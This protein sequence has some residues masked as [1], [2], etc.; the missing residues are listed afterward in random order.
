MKKKPTFFK[1]AIFWPIFYEKKKKKKFK[2]GLM[3]PFPMGFFSFVKKVF[4]KKFGV[5]PQKAW[6]KRKKKKFFFG[7]F[8]LGV[9]A[10]FFKT[11]FPPLLKWGPFTFLKPK[12]F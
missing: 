8:S 9:L 5:I 11:P 6:Q 7:G 4:N 12:T 3:V 2:V 1:N 10:K